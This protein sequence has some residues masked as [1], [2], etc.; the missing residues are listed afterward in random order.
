MSHDTGYKELFSHPEFVEALLDGFVPQEISNLLDY[1]T[2]SSHP[3]HYITPLFHEKIEDAVWSLQF[4]AQADIQRPSRLYLYILLEFQSSVDQQMPLRMLHYSAAFYHQLIK[5]G[6]VSTRRGLPLVFPLV[7]YNGQRRWTPPCNMLDMLHPAPAM[8]QRYQPQQ[9]YFLLDVS[10]YPS[11][12]TRNDNLLQLVF[13]VENARTADD[14][15]QVAWQL[16][17]GIRRHPQ[18]ERIDRVLTRWFKRFLH[19]NRINIDY[20]AVEKLQE[21]PPMLAN[22]VESWFEEW[23]QQGLEEGRSVGLKK[24]R[25]EGREEGRI[26]LLEKQFRLKF[27]ALDDSVIQRLHNATASELELWAERI[28]F[29]SS[30]EDVMR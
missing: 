19:Q 12:A 16:A 28:L 13:N 15:Q 24:G 6:R 25:E 5:Q 1:S 8:L 27:S 4:K 11:G 7:L 17:N 10:D 18:R 22:R 21:I 3:G 14:M 30:V 2:L 20:T 23:K 26:A 29:A 9:A